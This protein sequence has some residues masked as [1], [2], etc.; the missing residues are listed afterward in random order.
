MSPKSLSS[1]HYSI[2]HTGCKHIY[3]IP[4][5]VA[6]IKRM[7][8]L[9]NFLRFS[10]SI[11]H[12]FINTG[13]KFS[14]PNFSTLSS[15]LTF[16]F[17]HHS[18]LLPLLLSLV[19]ATFPNKSSPAPPLPLGA[20]GWARVRRHRVSENSSPLRP[21]LAQPSTAPHSCCLVSSPR[22]CRQLHRPHAHLLHRAHRRPSL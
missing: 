2:L 6:F 10:L 15:L 22:H 3:N 8:L 18:S 11:H 13:S 21:P 20:G 1:R 9:I 14:D 19:P 16:F 5:L 4:Q 7:C 17:L 12:P